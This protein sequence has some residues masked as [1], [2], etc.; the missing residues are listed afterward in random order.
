M[1][2]RD[3]TMGSRSALC[4][5]ALITVHP[6]NALYLRQPDDMLVVAS[7]STGVA[8]A[9][10]YDDDVDVA[11]AQYDIVVY[12]TAQVI[13]DAAMMAFDAS[14]RSAAKAMVYTLADCMFLS[15]IM[16][17][18]L[19]LCCRDCRKHHKPPPA[20]V[21]DATP[22]LAT[23]DDGNDRVGGGVIKA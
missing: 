10:Y 2:T 16:A 23:D 5:L 17:V 1:G 19:T 3:G 6:A 11:A 7:S 20:I 14:Q 13:R 18:L 12:E 21:V 9:T 8:A 4:I 22:V 15:V